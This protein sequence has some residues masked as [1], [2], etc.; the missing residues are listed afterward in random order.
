MQL[1][2]RRILLENSIDRNYGSQNWG[3]VTASTFTIN[4]FLKQNIDDMGLFTDLDF[5]PSFSSV[6]YNNLTNTDLLTLR[7]QNKSETDYYNYANKSITGSTDSKIDELMSYD[8]NNRYISG[9]DIE[10]GTYIDYLG[11]TING[12]SRLTSDL[13]PKIYVFDAKLDQ[14]IGT[15]SQITGLQ[16]KDYSGETKEVNIDGEIFTIPLT[17]FKYIGQGFNETNTSLSALIKEEYLFGVVSK[18]EIENDVFIERGV[19]SVL[20]M[21]LRMSEIKNLGELTRYGNGFYKIT[22]E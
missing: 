5:T 17:E 10:S 14:F 18:P 22:R 9:F 1:I 12:V 2:K 19:T 7:L 11:N 8:E 15:D 4:I 16:Y 21:H 3:N 20:D 6:T 13:D